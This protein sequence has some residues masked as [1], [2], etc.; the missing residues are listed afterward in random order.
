MEDFDWVEKVLKKDQEVCTV[1]AAPF[2]TAFRWDEGAGR[3]MTGGLG[4]SVGEGGIW[5][6]AATHKSGWDQ[7]QGNA[8]GRDRDL[9]GECLKI[10]PMPG[11]SQMMSANLLRRALGTSD[12]QTEQ[13]S[14]VQCCPVCSGAA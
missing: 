3:T 8:H 13:H 5:V 9:R 11:P 1:L 14:T 6:V 2:R 4:W 7:L 10:S 12:E